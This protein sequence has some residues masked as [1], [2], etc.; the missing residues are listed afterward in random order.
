M[1][2]LQTPTELNLSKSIQSQDQ[3]DILSYTMA[4]LQFVNPW[5]EKW[6][7]S[8]TQIDPKDRVITLSE[9]AYHDTPKDCWIVIYDRV[10]DITHFLDEVSCFN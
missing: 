5:S 3:T 9:V 10:Y 6:T 4:A 8:E 2:T 1:T 7:E